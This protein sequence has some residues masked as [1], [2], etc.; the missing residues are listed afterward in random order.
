MTSLSQRFHA[1]LQKIA[2]DGV[3]HGAPTADE[4]ARLR[5]V[6]AARQKAGKSFGAPMLHGVDHPA[7]KIDDVRRLQ[8]LRS[9]GHR[10]GQSFVAPPASG[11]DLA[12]APTEDALKRLRARRAKRQ[13][14]SA[15]TAPAAPAV[16][17]A[18]TAP[19]TQTAP[20]SGADLAAAPSADKVNRLRAQRAARQ[21][22]GKSFGAPMFHGAGTSAET[23]YGLPASNMQATPATA[24]TAGAP[25]AQPSPAAQKPDALQRFMQTGGS[26]T[27]MAGS[28]PIQISFDPKTQNWRATNA[29]GQIKDVAAG[30]ANEVFMNKLRHSYKG[31]LANPA[32]HNQRWEARKPASGWGN[33]WREGPEKFQQY[34]NKRF[35]GMSVDQQNKV[36]S[37]LQQ[38][39]GRG[40][41][42]GWNDDKHTGV[43][44]NIL[45]D[46]AQPLEDIIANQP[47][48]RQTSRYLTDVQKNPR[49]WRG[50]DITPEAAKV[51]KQNWQDHPQLAAHR[52]PP[53]NPNPQSAVATAQEL[54]RTAADRRRDTLAKAYR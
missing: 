42:Y 6:R 1:C 48:T 16:A 35:G 23:G 44:K 5:A 50:N 24:A 22:A 40:A 33:A 28:Q 13:A 4:I 36:L 19:T 52:A 38:A 25:A 8:A 11:A 9:K 49:R 26:F 47:L 3:Q 37:T 21:K 43:T 15:S 45:H 7:P 46:S 51:F 31:Y 53:V 34:A 32:Q 2:A 27:T 14:A 10:S 30:A 17:P 39:R 41:Q 29:S 12:A 18:A 20:A 54:A